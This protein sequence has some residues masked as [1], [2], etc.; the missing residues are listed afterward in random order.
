MG[1]VAMT[2]P[3]LRAFTEQHPDVIITVLS[4]SFLEPLFEDIDNVKFY[5][6]HLEDKHKGF[7]GLYRLFKELKKMDIDAIAD[8]HNVLRSKIL[9]FFFA[10]SGIKNAI[11]D[12][13]RAEKKALTRIKNKVFKQ[14][15][16][17]H[18]RYCDVFRKLGFK[19]DLSNPK[20]PSKQHLTPEI[21]KIITLDHKKWIGIAPFAK[22]KAKMYP[23]DLMEIV[24]KELDATNKYKILLFGGGNLEINA[25]KTLEVKF[26]NTISV[27]GK[28]NFMDE[29]R[30]ISNLDCMVSM[31]SANA[32]LGAM[33][34]VK[35]I[36]IWGATHPFAGFAPFNQPNE[37]MLL[38]D[39]KKFPNIPCSIYG[40]KNCAGYDEMMRTIPPEKI[41]AKI[42]KIA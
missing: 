24:I 42:K 23:L 22:H 31:D 34:G 36:T 25:L 2:V 35:I 32:H 20:F 11:I 17:T 40:N 39:L 14:L 16:T 27:A 8:I 26:K 28:I 33:Q 21:L 6:A 1:D 13:G 5:A 18:E 10:S 9:C 7:L 41:I 15:K 37:Y 30:L 12:K 38:P 29:I 4:R 3:V 19:V